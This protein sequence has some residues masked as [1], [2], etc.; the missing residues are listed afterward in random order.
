MQDSRL[1]DLIKDIPLSDM[2]DSKDNIEWDVVLAV[3][4]TQLTDNKER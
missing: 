4:K 1:W 3:L 2:V